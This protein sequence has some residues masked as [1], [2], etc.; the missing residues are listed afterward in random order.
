MSGRPPAPGEARPQ[1]V[2]IAGLMAS[3]KSEVGRLVAARL[4][5]TLLDSDVEIE[6]TTGRTVRELAAMVG[7]DAMHDHEE[8][9]L[10]DAL[11][12]DQ[13]VVIAP[14]ASTV[15]RAVCRRALRASAYVVWL[16]V[17][18]PL[19]VERFS[20]APHRPDFGRP[21]ADLLVDQMARRGP[22]FAEV[23]DL[24]LDVERSSTP[25]ALAD[26]VIASLRSRPAG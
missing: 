24:V 13:P 3:G 6:R 16:R 15:G 14:A 20:S 17:P 2:V 12:R 8:R 1:H 19:L 25:G 26:L 18:V 23:A 4:G 11:G 22:L 9:Q 10:L 7:A 5:R 21:V